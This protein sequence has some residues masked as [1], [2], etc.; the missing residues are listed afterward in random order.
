MLNFKAEVE[1]QWQSGLLIQQQC[2]TLVQLAVL[3]PC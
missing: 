1:P 3:K 2:H